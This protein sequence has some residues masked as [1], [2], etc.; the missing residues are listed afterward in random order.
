ML[1][2]FKK[3]FKFTNEGIILAIPLIFFIWLISLYLAF[4]RG[5]VDTYLEAFSAVLTL[6]CMVGAFCAGWFYMVKESIDT[7][8]KD[9]ILDEEKAKEILNLIKKFPT[10][11]GNYFIS[12]LGLSL[13]MLILFALFAAGI[14]KIGMHFIGSIDFT[15]EQLKDAMTSAQDMK[16]FLDS[17]SM[18]QLYKLAN[19]NMLF[20]AAS[21]IMSYLLMLWVPEIIYR[22]QNPVFALFYSIKKLFCKFWQSIGLFAYLTI[23]NIVISFANTFALIHP[24]IYM[25]LMVIY[26]YFL[27]YVV[28]L[29]FSYYDASFNKTDEQEEESNSDSR[30]DG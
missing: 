25:M 11:V 13:I 20:L 27:V 24:I 28:V 18:E 2:L 29:I 21:T 7:S 10:G 5:V 15:T 17:L 14:Y 30:S 12:F 9:F 1:K 23:L 22:T 26:F 4:A 6:L 16:I 19:W 3:A 8:K